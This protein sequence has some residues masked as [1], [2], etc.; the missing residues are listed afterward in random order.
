MDVAVH[1]LDY[2]IAELITHAGKKTHGFNRV[3]TAHI[4]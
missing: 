4:F 3:M 1:N 2:A